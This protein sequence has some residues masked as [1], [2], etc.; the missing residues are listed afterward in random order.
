MSV[1]GVLGMSLWGLRH[2]KVKACVT[3]LL[4]TV[5][6]VR[7]CQDVMGVVCYTFMGVVGSSTESSGIE[8]QLSEAR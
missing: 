8:R 6:T 1:K 5:M 4:N 3:K 2:T 7:E